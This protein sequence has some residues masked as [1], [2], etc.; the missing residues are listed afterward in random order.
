[1]ED[2]WTTLLVGVLVFILV[3]SAVVACGIQGDKR[4]CRAAGYVD[5]ES[6]NGSSWCVGM[7]DGEPYL[8]PVETIRA[9]K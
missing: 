8:V 1:M 2:F 9:G 3:L 5:Y 6:W 7:R 4:A